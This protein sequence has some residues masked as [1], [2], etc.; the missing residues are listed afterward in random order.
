ML[1]GVFSEWITARSGV[2]EFGVS[3]QGET[4]F[5]QDETWVRALLH[6]DAGPRHENAFV[7]VDDLIESV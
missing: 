7:L 5:T 4:A 3:T 6:A 2:I 1:F